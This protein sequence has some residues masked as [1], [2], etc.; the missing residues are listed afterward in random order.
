MRFGGIVI[1]D[2]WLL[3]FQTVVIVWMDRCFFFPTSLRRL[4]AM[5]HTH[6][7]H[8]TNT[9]SMTNGDIYVRI[10]LVLSYV[11]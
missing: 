11:P 6:A 7:K 10:I 8:A 3:G 9:V 2:V 4:D 5:P 1:F